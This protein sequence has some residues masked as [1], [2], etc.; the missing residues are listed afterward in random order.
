[1]NALV[2]CISR[3]VCL[4]RVLWMPNRRAISLESI[5]VSVCLA[6]VMKPLHFRLAS[7]QREAI[8]WIWAVDW[9]WLF[10]LVRR[11]FRLLFSVGNKWEFLFL[12]MYKVD[13]RVAF[14]MRFVGILISLWRKSEPCGSPIVFADEKS[15]IMSVF[16]MLCLLYCGEQKTSTYKI[17]QVTTSKNS[18]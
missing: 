8:L 3:W 15:K 1:M 10:S 5:S 6:V 16:C 18:K 11:C 14:I 4:S 2:T 12:C 9:L 17:V 13:T 7:R